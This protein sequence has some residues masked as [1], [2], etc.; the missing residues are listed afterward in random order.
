MNCLCCTLTEVRRD[1]EDHVSAADPDTRRRIGTN[2]LP[3]EP[4]V[5]LV[6]V[7]DDILM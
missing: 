4:A 5:G 1:A 6:G 2:L 7:N 3:K